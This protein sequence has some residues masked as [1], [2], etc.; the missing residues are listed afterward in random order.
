M[1]AG[2]GRPG[3]LGDEIDTAEA[4]GHAQVA[5][6]DAEQRDHLAMAPEERRYQRRAAVAAGRQAGLRAG[7]EHERC[8]LDPVAVAGL[9]QGRPAVVVPP[10]GVGAAIEQEADEVQIAA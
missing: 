10:V 5:R 7:G 4:C 3:E 1:R 9:V 8:Q 6:L 2:S